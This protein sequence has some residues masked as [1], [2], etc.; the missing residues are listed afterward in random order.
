MDKVQSTNN[1]LIQFLIEKQESI[2]ISETAKQFS[3][4]SKLVWQQI[5]KLENAG[6]SIRKAANE[7]HFLTCP[8]VLNEY[9]MKASLKTRWLGNTIVHKESLASTQ[10]TAHEYANHNA[11]H[12]TIII[13]DEQHEGKGT[14]NKSW[15][16]MKGKS[17][18]LSMIIRP[19][20]PPYLAPQFTLLTATVLAEAIHTY[21]KIKPQIKWPNDI[22]I[23]GKK[24][25]GILTE[26]NVKHNKINYIIIGIGMNV[27]QN[28]GDLPDHLD[29][30]ITSLFLNTDQEWNI[31][32]F[33]K[34]ILLTFEKQYQL[35][36]D[37]GFSQI[38]RNW[39]KNAYRLGEKLW[40]TTSN[41]AWQGRFLGL[42]ENGTL[43]MENNHGVKKEI[44]SADIN[45]LK[46]G[47]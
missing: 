9:T 12:G 22:L 41:K 28:I 15:Y 33:I 42:S 47:E 5:D 13:A 14:M 1:R 40:L 34:H 46:R 10:I 18:S 16:D 24:L 43:L 32:E 25:A 23:E 31:K 7:C 6:F 2:S 26:M 29:Q 21:M 3:M 8:T 37:T 27:N 11:S 38:K 44:Y 17:I 19:D 35:Y 30:S 4:S 20:I 36:L 39:E 45:W